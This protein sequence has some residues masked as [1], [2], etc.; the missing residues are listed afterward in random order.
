MIISLLLFPVTLYYLSPALIIMGAF[1]GI[2]TGSFV[3]FAAM[4]IGSI[5]FGR[6]FCGY[7]CPA[8]SLQDCAALITDKKPKLGWRNNLKYIIWIVWIAA[9]IFSFLIHKGAFSLDV[10]YQTEYGI[11]VTN[12][13]SYV[14]YYGIVLL[15]FMPALISG[16]RA[17]CHYF[18]WMAPFMVIGSRIGRLLH[19]KRLRLKWDKDKCMSCGICDK[20]CPMS[21]DVSRRVKQSEMYDDECILCGECVDKCPKKV[22]SYKF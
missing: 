14:I 1:E 7:I 3:A 19:V 5:F 6:I 15:F 22:I 18:C 4:L 21:I 17:S 11:S 10:F 9:V 8:G 12:V 16:K 13:Y 20:A 2:I